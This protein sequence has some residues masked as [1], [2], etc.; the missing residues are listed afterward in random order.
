[1]LLSIRSAESLTIKVI[2]VGAILLVG[3]V[4]WAPAMRRLIKQI[5]RIRVLRLAYECELAVGQELDLLMLR[6]YQ[7]FHN[8]PA[9]GFN[10]DH[11]V[12]GPAGVF[13]VETKGD[14]KR[15]TAGEGGVTASFKVRYSGGKLEFP[16]GT[17]TTTVPQ[18]VRQARWL[19]KWLSSAV[20]MAVEVAQLVVLPGWFVE[21]KD[22]PNVAVIA[23]G[24]IQGYFK[25]RNGTQLSDEQIG[26]LVHQ[27]DA[28]VR[29]LK[30]GE[31]VRPAELEGT[32]A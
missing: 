8:V 21:I 16:F 27:L 17:D 24:Y 12:V 26:R 9:E 28:K 23:S 25:R 14:S 13:A 1:M 4:I 19:G 7:V 20:G 6:G 11:V 15:V 10:I 30:P 29:D 31:L 5:E 3:A 32:A 22:R 2:L 18:A